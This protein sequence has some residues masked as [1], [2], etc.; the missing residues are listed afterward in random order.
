MRQV[1]SQSHG[2]HSIP[3]PPSI[4]PTPCT[5]G[6]SSVP[7]ATP[8]TLQQQQAGVK[9]KVALGGLNMPGGTPQKITGTLHVSAPFFP[10]PTVVWVLSTGSIQ[11]I[12]HSWG[13][14]SIPEITLSPTAP[15]RS[16]RLCQQP[17]A[18]VKKK[19]IQK[20]AFS[21]LLSVF[22]TLQL[23]IGN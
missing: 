11:Q 5:L 1:L 6:T 15:A 22:S 13:F 9:A 8:C 17:H 16:A 2:T 10:A 14:C 20:K 4:P 7:S 19:F 23:I 12:P 21:T 18:R 3:S